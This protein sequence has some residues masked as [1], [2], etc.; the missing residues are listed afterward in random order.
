MKKR[1]KKGEEE[2]EEGRVGSTERRQLNIFKDTITQP[3]NPSSSNHH[4]NISTIS[5]ISSFLLSF[6]L[7]VVRRIYAN[8]K[9][10]SEMI[11]NRTSVTHN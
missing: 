2:E 6:S 10:E 5:T 4:H 8:G 1:E 7:R 11:A 9:N 3:I